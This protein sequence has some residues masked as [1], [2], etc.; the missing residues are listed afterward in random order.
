MSADAIYRL[1]RKAQNEATVFALSDLLRV[2]E[3][4]RDHLRAE[5]AALSSKMVSAFRFTTV[6]S[7]KR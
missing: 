1:R 2:A 6:K 5:P 4:E 7:T 3:S